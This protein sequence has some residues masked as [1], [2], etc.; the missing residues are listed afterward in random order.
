MRFN[1][2]PAVEDSV[3]RTGNNG[4]Y[5]LRKISLP[6]PGEAL[7]LE[8]LFC[9]PKNR[10]GY[11][12]DVVHPKDQIVLHFTAG[13][14]RSDLGALTGHQRHVSVPFIIARDGTIYQLFSSKFWSG[15]IGKGLGNEGTGNA[16]DKRTIGIELSNYGF[17]T[18]REGKLETYY[19][20][21]RNNDGTIGLPDIYCSLT[22]IGA[23]QKLQE[24]F[25]NQRYYATYTEAQYQSLI[26]LLR[27]L[28]ATYNIPRQFL[29]EPKRYTTTPDVLSFKGIVSHINYRKDGKWDIGPAFEWKKVIQG[30]QT[31]QFQPELTRAA[32]SDESAA[33][34][35]TITIEA[36]LDALLPAPMP[37]TQEN[38]PYQELERTLSEEAMGAAPRKKNLYA[39]LVGIDQY[40]GDIILEEAVT[41]P[42][43]RGCKNDV[44][45]VK[46]YLQNDTSYNLH[47]EVLTDAA[48]SKEQVVQYFKRH[49][50]KAKQE[51]V[52]LFYYSGHGTR[53]KANRLW[54]SESDGTLECLACYFDEATQ[55]KF[56]LADKEL[57]HLIHEVYQNKPHIVTI[58]DCCHSGDIT[59]NGAINA[60]AFSSALERR[61]PY[62]FRER[63]WDDFIFSEDITAAQ[64][65]QL[66]A[67]KSTPEGHHVQLSAC[68]SNESAMEVGGEGVFTKAL[69]KVLDATNGQVTY[70]SLRSRV[71]QYLRSN[72]EQ[73][74]RI[75]AVGTGD[76]L[77][78]TTFLNKAIEGKTTFGE[79]TFNEREGW[80]LNLGSV[81][82]IGKKNKNIQLLDPDTHAPL[83]KATVDLVKTDYAELTPEIDLD[84]D[85]V[86]LA[87]VEGLLSQQVKVHLENVD[88][89]VA[90]QLL[91]TDAIM[92]KAKGFILLESQESQASY[93]VRARNGSYYITKPE[94]VYRP[95]TQPIYISTP[96]AIDTIANQLIHLSQWEYIRNLTNQ[97]ASSQLKSDAL[98]VE[99]YQIKDDKPVKLDIS[100]KEVTMDYGFEEEYWQ[101]H[102]S[103]RLIN[104]L[105]VPLYCSVAYLTVWFGSMLGLLNPKVYM[106]AAKSSVD[107]PLTGGALTNRLQEQVRLYSWKEQTEFLKFIYSTEEIDLQLLELEELPAP[108]LPREYTR[109]EEVARGG[110]VL[111][112]T[113][114]QVKRGWTSE[115]VTLRFNNPVYN[116]LPIADITAMLNDPALAD[117]ALGLYFD[118]SVGDTLQPVYTLKPVFQQEAEEKGFIQ[119]K[120]LDLAN[121]W[122]RN[123][124]N[125]HYAE[126]RRQF[127]EKVRIVSEGDSW[128]QHPLVVD[129]ID[130][131]SRLY[132][133]YCV[134]AAG[135][136]L[137][138][139]MSAR[140][141]RGEY[142]LQA[143]EREQPAFFLL[144]GGGNDILG[145]QFRSYL[146]DH[147]DQNEP[148]GKNPRRFLKDSLFAELNSLMEIYRTMFNHI[149]THYPKLYVLVHGYDY[150]IKL[151]D[152]NKGWL[153]RY[154]IEK[155]ISRPEDRKAIIRLIMDTFNEQL[156]ATTATFD[157]NV[158][159]IDVRNIV[160]YNEADG[161]DQWYDE[162][163]PNNE[164]FQLV[165]MKIIVKIDTIIKE[166]YLK[167]AASSV[168]EVLRDGSPRLWNVKEDRSNAYK[169]TIKEITETPIADSDVSSD[170][171]RSIKPA[172]NDWESY[173]APNPIESPAVLSAG[174]HPV[175]GESK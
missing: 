147:P 140:W 33:L 168:S 115:L 41:F 154:M 96:S 92:E 103:I 61:V 26:I 123:R 109:G 8:G 134:A 156:K 128:F 148:A 110:F 28:T 9:A 24:A 72:F 57:R 83:C 164:G 76:E 6:V 17:L 90:D 42:A 51:D 73:K 113:N 127:P 5:T 20:R 88:G 161:V 160:Q 137:R 60:A 150:P 32:L 67:S 101:T 158:F 52:A 106:L 165:A 34:T 44:E 63:R 1:S 157:E 43:L 98:S 139:Y 94:D 155:G 132:P 46:T 126:M 21:Q 133:V 75:Y 13:Q 65:Q 114:K 130:H 119:D 54:R 30:V 120:I 173:M 174:A 4:E 122:A 35:P 19:S 152:S 169:G 111:D 38:A 121:W 153:G 74:P 163:H 143:L 151:N 85:K 129:V 146:V 87:Y 138:N 18:E 171:Y 131:I 70:Q 78:Y 141:K 102:L 86:Y 29:E 116:K 45:K 58:F 37:A 80:L 3:R 99:L 118:A 64:M 112:G 144:S 124:R 47:V 81:H 104:N 79:V 25:R 105:D 53:E 50:G 15:H 162:I 149:K 175:E 97:V 40:R 31:T 27:Y 36:E 59:R 84:V 2:L 49:L 68:E 14:I 145:S 166:Q 100:Q 89:P 39:L 117:F 172:V 48:A 22:E 23:Y 69:L 170:P 62:T 56:L 91:L 142:F 159:Y 55:D 136:T 12:Y 108:P 93:T 82:G 71:R 107:I 11:Y 16:Q 167:A 95:L 135:D 77:L 66:E 10:S 7:Q 125:R